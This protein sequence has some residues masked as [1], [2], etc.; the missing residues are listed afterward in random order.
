ML[1]PRIFGYSRDDVVLAGAMIANSV[2]DA[3]GV[4]ITR[5]PMTPG[6]VAAA[7]KST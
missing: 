3:T 4:R 5:L 1:Q 6:R 7:M 2:F